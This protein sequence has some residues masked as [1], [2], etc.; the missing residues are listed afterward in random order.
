MSSFIYIYSK[1]TEELLLLGAAGIFSLL[2]VY[3]Y[4]WV[5]RKRRLGAARS[6]IPSTVVKAYLSQLIHE[7]QFVRTQ[8]FGIAQANSTFEGEAAP[9]P[10]GTGHSLPDFPAGISDDLSERLRALQSQLAEKE[11]LVININVEKTKLLEELENLRQNQNAVRSA[12]A[13]TSSGNTEDLMKKIKTLEDRLEEYSLFEEDL[14][15]LK[16]LQQ[17]NT[18]LKKRIEEIGPAIAAPTIAAT[19]TLAVA[20]P[21]AAEPSIDP[22]P[23]TQ[24]A[25]DAIDAL[26]DGIPAVPPSATEINPPVADAPKAPTGDEFERLVDSVESSLDPASDSPSAPE[27]LATKSDEELLKEFENLLNS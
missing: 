21:P 22:A 20:P 1:F 17:E 18:S 2:S 16:R 10:T 12:A 6:E 24:L 11:S 23:P 15:N 27:T 13:N 4:H 9:H 8:L 5:I 14:A 19:P 26:L 25:Q 7:A 3:C